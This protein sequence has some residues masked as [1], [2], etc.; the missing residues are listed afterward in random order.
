[1][2]G[3]AVFM[4]RRKMPDA[5]R[6]YKVWGYPLLPALFILFSAIFI[7]FVLYSDITAYIEGRSPL[8]NSLM[9][10]LL[11]ALGLPGYFYWRRK[12]KKESLQ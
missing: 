11:V 12:Q 8:I 7:V 10:A 6:P 9:G 1:M 3:Y 5:P 2:A 4:L